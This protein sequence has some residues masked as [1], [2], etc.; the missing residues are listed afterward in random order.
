LGDLGRVVSLAR[1]NEAL[2]MMDV[3][4]RKLGWMTTTGLRD[5]RTV[6]RPEP[7]DSRSAMASSR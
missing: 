6:L 5:I 2:G 1:V 7:S 4:L 3:S